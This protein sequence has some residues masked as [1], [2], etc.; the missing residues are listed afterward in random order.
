MIKKLA[1]SIVLVKNRS[2]SLLLQFDSIGRI[3]YLGKNKKDLLNKIEVIDK[4]NKH[5]SSDVLDKNDMIFSSWCDGADLEPMI[6]VED[7]N[8]I[9][10]NR[11]R[12]QSFKILNH[13]DHNFDGPHSRNKAQTLRVSYL[14]ETKKILVE[15][16]IS[17]HKDSDA[18]VFS[19]KITNLSLETLK[20]TKA[21]SVQLDFASIDNTLFSLDGT[22]GR[23]RN[24]TQTE[25][26][27]GIFSVKSSSGY[28]SNIHNPFVIVRNGNTYVSANLIYSGSH[29][30]TIEALPIGKS[31]FLS[32][33]NSDVFSWT[34]E[35]Q[36]SFATPEAVI[37]FGTSIDDVSLKM[38]G[39]VKKDIIRP[40]FLNMKPRVLL[41][42]WEGI[43][44]D[45][46]R[47]KIIELARKAKSIGVDLF[48]LDDGWFGKRDNDTSKCS[49]CT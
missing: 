49:F 41:N 43:F 48:V 21:M 4:F 16:F 18:L 35:P 10:V 20:I 44:F 19:L 12:V 46:N 29:A 1:P 45:F 13:Y 38:H 9:Y 15:Q 42:S 47:P 37:C 8:G 27:T 22:W 24:L 2:T 30:E 33:L 26:K 3:L 5:A 25:V 40:E 14:D 36:D 32:G 28:S 39:F 34:L 31:R 7:S 11:F 17:M 23:E 6:K